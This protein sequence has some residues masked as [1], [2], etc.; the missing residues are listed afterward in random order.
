MKLI[1]FGANGPT[2]RILTRL[3]LA[4]GY[5]VVAFTRRPD[6]FPIEHPGLE[7]V[8]GDVHDA[9]AVKAA[10]AGTDAVLSTLGVPFAKTPVT[11]YSD[12]VGNIM[13]GMRAS[14][15]K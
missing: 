2:G 4:E 3:A 6:S 11:V 7:L 15:I 9:A 10:I 13:S 5:E 14:G 8:A 12:G 1:V